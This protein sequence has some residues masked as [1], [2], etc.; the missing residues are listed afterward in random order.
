MM[1][2]KSKQGARSTRAKD[3]IH[4][5]AKAIAYEAKM[6]FQISELWPCRVLVHPIFSELIIESFLVHYR[7]LREFLYPS[8]PSLCDIVAS[9]FSPATWVF[10]SSDWTEMVPEE[11]ARIGERLSL[12]SYSRH[13]FA[14]RWPVS[15]MASAVLERFTQFLQTL[16]KEER[17]LFH[18]MS[19]HQFDR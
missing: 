6:V 17:S 8:D 14:K 16:P 19:D 2:L 9:D 11:R 1:S 18:Y 3:Q 4:E 13:H 5:G 7:N 12:R 15:E 10:V